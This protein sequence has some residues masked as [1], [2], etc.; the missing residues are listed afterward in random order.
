MSLMHAPKQRGEG[1]SKQEDQ[2]GEMKEKTVLQIL[3][4]NDMEERNCCFLTPLHSRRY[5]IWFFS[6]IL[7][8]TWFYLFFLYISKQ[9]VWL[10]TSEYDPQQGLAGLLICIIK[11]CILGVK[12]H[13]RPP[14]LRNSLPPSHYFTEHTNFKVYVYKYFVVFLMLL[15]FWSPLLPGFYGNQGT[16]HSLER[17]SV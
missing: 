5:P 10:D 6:I 8:A 2:M 3:W 7:E 15:A 16:A 17:S 12:N 13:A 9:I 1:A 11:K 14:A 4:C